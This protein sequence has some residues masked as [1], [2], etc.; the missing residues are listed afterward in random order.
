M[1][2]NDVTLDDLFPERK[3]SESQK[4]IK[5]DFPEEQGKTFSNVDPIEEAEVFEG[6][7]N[8]T[9]SPDIEAEFEDLKESNFNNE[10]VIDNDT[11]AAFINFNKSFLNV[12]S[13]LDINLQILSSNIS[14]LIEPK[15]EKGITSKHGNKHFDAI[16]YL[17]KFLGKILE[18]REQKNSELI[19]L[20]SEYK[21]PESNVSENILKIIQDISTIEKEEKEEESGGNIQNIL[22]NKGTGRL[23]LFLGESF[24]IGEMTANLLDGSAINAIEQL[25]EKGIQ[26]ELLQDFIG[27]ISQKEKDELGSAGYEE[28]L[29]KFGTN[30]PKKPASFDSTEDTLDRVFNGDESVGSQTGKRAVSYTTRTGDAE[31]YHKLEPNFKKKIDAL[32]VEFKRRTGRD[33]QIESAFRTKDEQR[34]LQHQGGR[35]PVASPERS[36]HP[37]GKAVDV[38]RQD[39]LFLR[40]SGILKQFGLESL[41]NDIIH[42]QETDEAPKNDLVTIPRKQETTLN[43]Q[44]RAQEQ[45]KTKDEEIKE[46]LQTFF[47][48]TR[49]SSYKNNNSSYITNITYEEQTHYDIDNF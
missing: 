16:S 22:F 20:F 23:L 49:S 19:N 11:K 45:L 27:G 3:E 40:R 25:F 24:L 10:S 46:N 38:A 2:N 35:Y 6:E 13:V 21:E 12:F 28:A 1:N 29:D 36:L 42:I 5:D 4:N 32:S 39:A 17:G 48:S 30:K 47:S 14:K 33:L 18:S 37:K 43:L 31:H 15:Q 9:S 8:K 44:R 34:N 41:N 7:D 26:L